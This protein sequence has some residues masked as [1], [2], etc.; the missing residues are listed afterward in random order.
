ML[1]YVF[2]VV[3]LIFVIASALQKDLPPL[4]PVPYHIFAETAQI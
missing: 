2:A 3:V 4:R 1:S